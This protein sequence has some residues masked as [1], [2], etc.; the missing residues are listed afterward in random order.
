M[1]DKTLDVVRDCRELAASRLNELE[2][3]RAKG[4]VKDEKILALEDIV[5]RADERIKYLESIKC[6]EFSILKLGF[7]KLFSWK[8]CR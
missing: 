8:K 5:K 1:L 4:A 2:I 7:I 6:S 3:S